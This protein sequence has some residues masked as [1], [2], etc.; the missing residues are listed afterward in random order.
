MGLGSS[1]GKFSSGQHVVGQSLGEVFWPALFT[2]AKT[3]IPGGD[4]G[5]WEI[6]IIHKPPAD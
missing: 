4:I 6:S 3:M 1:Y 5:W 2:S